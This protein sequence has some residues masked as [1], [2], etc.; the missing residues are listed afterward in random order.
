ML[1]RVRDQRPSHNNGSWISSSTGVSRAKLV[2]YHAFAFL[3]GVAGGFAS[4][5]MV[6]SSWTK[7]HIAALWKRSSPA[8]VFPPCD[9]SELEVTP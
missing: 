4:N 5:V 9:T 7:R 3:Y 1:S 8:V 6:N 2:Y